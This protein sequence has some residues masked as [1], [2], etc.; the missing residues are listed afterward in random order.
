MQIINLRQCPQAMQQLAQWHHDEWADYNP[1]V[2]ST[3]VAM[4][5]EILGSA[6][7][8][9]HD[10]TIHQELTPWLASVYVDEP[11]RRQ[12]IGSQLVRH[13]MQQASYAGYS[14]LYLFTPDQV[15]FY[16][17]L[18]WQELIKEFYCGHEVTIMSADLGQV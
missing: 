16:Q 8:V 2:P 4:E 14:K 9:Q 13:V 5:Y 7:I 10:M 18:G 11:H 12:G 1:A 15:E 3:F 6:D 17:H